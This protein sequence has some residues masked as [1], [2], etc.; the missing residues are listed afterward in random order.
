MYIS[1]SEGISCMFYAYVEFLEHQ[2]YKALGYILLSWVIFIGRQPSFPLSPC[3]LRFFQR[4]IQWFLFW[5]FIIPH[6]PWV[7][8]PTHFPVNCALWCN[9]GVINRVLCAWGLFRFRKV[10]V[11]QF[12]V[13]RLWICWVRLFSCSI[14]CFWASPFQNMRW[15]FPTLAGRLGASSSCR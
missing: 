2:Y 5:F 4:D 15:Y 13:Q 12:F 7:S 11:C 14:S 9:M 1:G 10:L 8:C 6:V 3:I